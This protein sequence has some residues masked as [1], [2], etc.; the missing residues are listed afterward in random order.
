LG[1]ATAP[2]YP[3]INRLLGMLPMVTNQSDPWESEFENILRN[4]L[5]NSLDS[6]LLTHY[7]K[8]VFV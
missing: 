2:G 3:A 5:S 4:T 6:L 7:L 8:V 1:L